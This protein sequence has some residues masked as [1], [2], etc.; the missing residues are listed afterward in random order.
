MFVLKRHHWESRLLY[1]SRQQRSNHFMRSE[2]FNELIAESISLCPSDDL[3]WFDCI[4]FECFQC[5]SKP[6]QCIKNL[7]NTFSTV[8]NT[9]P[10]V[11]C[12]WNLLCSML[13]QSKSS[14]ESMESIEP[15][16]INFNKSVGF[17]SCLKSLYDVKWS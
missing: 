4:C 10:T 14:V 13:N 16:E 17:F 11:C 12:R 6:S 9:F 5:I 2:H 15:T 7:F 1:Q 3:F 8:F